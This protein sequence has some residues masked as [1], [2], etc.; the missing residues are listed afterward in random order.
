MEWTSVLS[1]ALVAFILESSGLMS[2]RKLFDETER[3]ILRKLELEFAE[4]QMKHLDSKSTRKVILA[5][6]GSLPPGRPLSLQAS[7]SRA[8]SPSRPLSLS[9]SR[10]L[11]LSP[12][13]LEGSKV[14]Y[15]SPD[16]FAE[17]C[18]NSGVD[19]HKSV[20]YAKLA[21]LTEENEREK[22]RERDRE[23]IRQAVMG[24]K[25]VIPGFADEI[26]IAGDPVV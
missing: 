14:F 2:L 12:A 16:S 11:S 10:S 20:F 9:L 3:R 21:S 17:I 18:S 15:F 8:V 4:E 13:A 5:G 22:E 1:S 26:G 25:M 24:K 7:S 6:S 19:L 23:R